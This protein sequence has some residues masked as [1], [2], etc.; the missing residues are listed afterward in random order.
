MTV[1][2]IVTEYLKANEFDG[3]Y[4]PGE[5]ACEINDIMPC[6]GEGFMSCEAGYKGPC[7]P[8]CGDCDFH[9][10]PEKP[11]ANPKVQ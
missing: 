6:G 7:P 8:E 11:N 3:L 10:G 2:E 1:K 4:S 5:C 9:I